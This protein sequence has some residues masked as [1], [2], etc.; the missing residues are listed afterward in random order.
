MLLK[1]KNNRIR[2][3]KPIIM[4]LDQVRYLIQCNQQNNT[5]KDHAKRK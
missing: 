4:L 3:I 1:L 2:S 5:Y